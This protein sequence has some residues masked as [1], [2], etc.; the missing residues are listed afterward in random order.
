[1]KLTV[2]VPSMPLAVKSPSW[3]TSTVTASAAVVAPVRL[4]VNAAAVPSETVS[5]SAEIETVGGPDTTVTDRSSRS[6]ASLP[7][8]SWMG[9]VPAV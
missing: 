5:A 9:L 6:S 2:R 7:A 1:M 4:S 8:L 3:V